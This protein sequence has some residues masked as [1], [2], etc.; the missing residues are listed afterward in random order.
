MS[1][2]NHIMT[3]QAS[4]SGRLPFTSLEELKRV[5]LMGIGGT[6]MSGLAGM[7]HSF[8]VKVTGS[9]EAA[10]PPTSLLLDALHI[11]PKI[12]YAA[13][14]LAPRPDLVIV[15]NV[16]RRDN[17]EAMEMERLGLPYASLPECLNH[18]FLA[19]KRLIVVAGTHGKTTVSSMIAWILMRAGMDPSFL[20]GGIHGNVGANYRMG[21]GQFF[22]LEG[23][24]YDTAYFDKRPKILHYRPYI[25]V[26]TSCEF[27]HADIYRDV[28]Q[29]EDQFRRFVGQISP[30]GT[31]VA[32]AD[33]QNVMEIGRSF[34]GRVAT[35]GSA[36]NSTWTITHA[37]HSGRG[38][39]LG[40]VKDGAPVAEG[41][42]PF[43]GL[44][45]AR[46]A[47]AAV[48]AADAAG[49]PPRTSLDALSTYKM[50]TR[51]QQIL[52]S[53]SSVTI[54]DDFAHH[55]TA[56]RETVNA[57]R[58]YHK[59][60]RLIAVF[61]PRSN[62]SRTAIFQEAY[63]NSFSDA[64][65]VLVKEPAFRATD[66]LDNRFDVQRL[67]SDLRDRGLDAF[68]FRTSEALFD[69]LL[70]HLKPNDVI[71]IMTNGH[72]D[73]L[74]SKLVQVLQEEDVER[75]AALRKN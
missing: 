23:D 26:L 6:G 32:C 69:F 67:A 48:I 59:P 15:G 24:E 57:V 58:I 29:I 16:V 46:N 20:I 66:P 21:K 31:L 44:H 42:V 14:N 56:V 43:M 41:A 52:L 68:W 8:G 71:L 34:S 9:D 62:S 75:S 63:A 61:E 4:G 17:P 1:D 50:T 51:R 49:V 3:G 45:N 25:G 33:Y 27:D 7:F 47:L 35:Y 73:N 18:F 2:S 30:S 65:M 12:G 64:D 22:V 19:D 55:P 54:I 5:H 40:V 60:Q 72:F 13:E 38:M 37:S 36:D 10:Y 39:E 28:R 11:H 74:A 53:T 70:N